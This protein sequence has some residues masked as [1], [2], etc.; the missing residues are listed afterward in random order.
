MKCGMVGLPNAGKSTLFNALMKKALAHAANFPFCTIE[1]NIGQVPVN[2]PRL[3]ELSR[4]A[5]THTIIP[6]TLDCVDIAGLIKGASKGEGLGN[7]FLGNI[8]SVDLIL[9]VVR[10][11]TDSFSGNAA[12]PLMDISIIETELMLADIQI[13]EKQLSSKASRTSPHTKLCQILLDALMSEKPITK[14]DLLSMNLTPDELTYI[15]RL[16]LITMKP[17]LYVLNISE[18]DLK[19]PLDFLHELNKPYVKCCAKLQDEFNKIEDLQEREILLADYDLSDSSIDN[20][21][22]EGYKM[23]NLLTYFTAG[24][25]EVRAWQITNGMTTPQAA[26]KIHGDFERGFICA[27]VI[28]Y[29]DFIEFGGWTGCRNTGK[30]HREGKKYIV[31]DGDVCLFRHNT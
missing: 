26:G 12:T 23:L 31:Q 7:Q 27:E 16:G 22:R 30:I 14:S 2:D 10:T 29:S 9:H 21:L 6:T 24:E 25:K 17:M 4:I 20:I 13:L 28:G 3:Q 1:P 19:K 8:R 11:F 15:D 5:G 18:E